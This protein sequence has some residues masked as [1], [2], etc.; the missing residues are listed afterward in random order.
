MPQPLALH[1]QR[2]LTAPCNRDDWYGSASGKEKVSL[3][4]NWLLSLEIQSGFEG[5]CGMRTSPR[6]GEWKWSNRQGGDLLS[7]RVTA[8]WVIC[9]HPP[10]SQV[11]VEGYIHNVT[12]T[13]AFC[14]HYLFVFCFWFVHNCITAS[15]KPVFCYVVRGCVCLLPRKKLRTGAISGCNMQCFCSEERG[16]HPA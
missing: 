11:A 15:F 1:A 2:S 13:G 5:I 8:C 10:V 16:V 6:P 9:R 14:P 4:A 12:H 7:S 3:P